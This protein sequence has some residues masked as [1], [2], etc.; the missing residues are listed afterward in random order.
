MPEPEEL[1]VWGEGKLLKEIN[2][3]RSIPEKQRVLKKQN[4]LVID[5]D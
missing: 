4:T 2:F 1:I 5:M 3:A